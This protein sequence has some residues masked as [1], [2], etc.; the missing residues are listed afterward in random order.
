ME[1][2]RVI[3]VIP[4]RMGS[5]RYPGKP[6]VEILGLPMVE[7]VRRRAELCPAVDEVVVATCDREIFDLVVARGGKAV[8]TADTHE[9]CTERVEEAMRSLDG[10]I[11]AIVQ[12]DEPLL[13]P[14]AVTAIVAPLVDD[15]AVECSNLL[16]TIAD[17]ADLKDR[18]IVKAALDQ[19]GYVMYFSRASIPYFRHS[20]DAPVYRQTGI[21]A[22][23]K[24]FL[25]TYVDWPETPFE[26]VESIDM[27]RVLERGHR[28]RGVVMDYTTIGVDNPGDVAK[29][30]RLLSAD[31][32][33]KALHES[34]VRL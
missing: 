13:I 7:H 14:E 27:L 28:I 3:A 16:S 4:A 30:E 34:V 15:A 5:S 32:R 25:R 12:G 17:A 31:A 18:N 11:V 22:L 33:Q 8:M 19:E 6:L 26:R 20:G 21:W 24:D 2:P 9:R 10:D 29:V 1:K 23:R